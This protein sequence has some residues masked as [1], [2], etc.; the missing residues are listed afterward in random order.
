MFFGPTICH[1]VDRNIT[2]KVLCLSRGNF[3]GKGSLR[4]TEL[5]AACSH[6]GVE[7]EC[8][9]EFMDGPYVWPANRIQNIVHEH[10]CSFK[11]TCIVTFDKNGV[12]GHRNHM[13]LA[14]LTSIGKVKVLYLESLSLIRKFMATL[15]LGMTFFSGKHYVVAG[16]LRSIKA[17]FCH[18]SQLVWFRLLY[19][20]FSRY[21]TINSFKSVC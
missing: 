8:L 3:Y 5:E 4:K 7:S 9:D 17:M 2:T 10:V 6:F 15:D 18:R 11:A 13:S 1:L 16:S 12:S 19:I 20:C 21:M 14:N